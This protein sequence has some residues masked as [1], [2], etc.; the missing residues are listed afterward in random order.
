MAKVIQNTGGKI[1][2]LPIAPRL[3][4]ILSLAGSAAGIDEVVVESGGQCALG[5]CNKRTGS[6]RHDLGNAADVDLKKDGRLLRFTDVADL[7]FFKAFV[8][9]A[10]S[11]GATGIGGD[12][13]Y[14]GPSRIHVGFGSRATWGGD[15]G[16]GEAPS[17]LINAARKGW[18]NP[19]A[20]TGG[21]NDGSLFQVNARDGLNLRS[22]PGTDFK[23]LRL[24]PFGTLLVILRLDGSSQEWA[25][26]DLDKDGSTDGYVFKSFLKQIQ[27]NG[28]TPT[29]MIATSI[30]SA[31]A[32]LE[33][34][35][36]G[37]SEDSLD[38][39]ISSPGYQPCGLRKLVD[40][41]VI[42]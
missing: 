16:T 1:R 11:F 28:P 24:L 13:G 34:H 21:A 39:E 41:E 42:N 18:N 37:C 2:D 14:M 40:N 20:V 38:A 30:A 32:S 5:T 35:D 12:V 25:Q 9:A 6:T 3:K 29:N 17:W 10:A 31:Q 36:E 8:E 7:V 27:P 22:G 19:V 33:Q 26:V 23:I 15:G 4:T